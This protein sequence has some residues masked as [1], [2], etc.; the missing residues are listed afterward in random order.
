MEFL[1]YGR[2]QLD[3]KRDLIFIIPFAGRR[4]FYFNG[5]RPLR[6][7]F[8]W[9]SLEVAEA[10]AEEGEEEEDPHNSSR[11]DSVH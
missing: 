7:P 10:N 5:L 11:I 6:F 9:S 3:I 2:P 1:V 8:Q 4:A